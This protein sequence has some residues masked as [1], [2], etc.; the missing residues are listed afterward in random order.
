MTWYSPFKTINRSTNTGKRSRPGFK[1]GQYLSAP[2]PF[3]ILPA[4][5][6]KSTATDLHRQSRP[7]GRISLNAAR[8][9]AFPKSRLTSRRLLPT[10]HRKTAPSSPRCTGSFSTQREVSGSIST[11]PTATFATSGRK[12]LHCPLTASVSI[13]LKAKR[14]LRFCH[15]QIF[16]K[17]RN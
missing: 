16:H 14:T 1:P 8:L 10:F 9:R 17:T 12:F 2:L 7:S 11:L 3:S 4:T 5:P 15:R 13:S 6:G